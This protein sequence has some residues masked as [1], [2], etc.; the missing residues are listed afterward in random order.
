[1][2]AIRDIYGEG[3][4]GGVRR[5][6]A[7]GAHGPTVG[8]ICGAHALVTW[9]EALLP[10]SLM[11]A[12]R[13]LAAFAASYAAASFY[14]RGEWEWVDS[15]DTGGWS[16]SE[17]AQFASCLQFEPAVWDWVER[18]G[19]DVRAEYWSVVGP[20][21]REWNE[22][23]IRRA[24]AGLLGARRAFRAIAL[25]NLHRNASKPSDLVA[26]VLE[27]GMSQNS[28]DE[29]GDA[30]YDIQELIGCLQADASFDRQR[31]ARIEWG[32]LPVLERSHSN[33]GPD[34]LAAAAVESPAF[35]LEL[36]R[37]AYR[38]KNDPPAASRD[39]DD[40]RFNARRA[41][42]FLDRWDRLP[43][44]NESGSIDSHTLD[45][46][47]TSVLELSEDSGHSEITAHKIGQFIG[48]SVYP[49]LD[50]AEVLSQ[51]APIVDSH[52]SESLT[53][54]LINGILNSRGVTARDPFDGGA[55]EHE[56]AAKFDARAK[57]I[58]SVSPKLAKCFAAIQS[59]YEDHARH[60][61]E[62]AAR[63]RSGR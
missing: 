44:M 8:F 37:A 56:L 52:G 39:S 40:L 20:S 34:T 25:V 22:P 14:H 48:R 63:L 35:Y 31:L 62:E 28:S 17:R 16:S 41:V 51:L 60:E 2:D 12:D 45:E 15:L 55:L 5:L 38:G 7:L 1:M 59:H 4:F 47:I 33:T 9:G 43:G 24:V 6:L 36:I 26:E 57:K 10:Q 30:G 29:P 19:P 49:Y 46:W 53:Q 23:V 54:G 61:D 32:Y 13:S 3:G 18:Q 11:D 27:A 58:K 50:Q 21:A 42:E